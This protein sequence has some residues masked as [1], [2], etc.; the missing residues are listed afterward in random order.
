MKAR[1]S[2]IFYILAGIEYISRSQS[3]PQPL[4]SIDRRY[5]VPKC[6]TVLRAIWPIL[7]AS[8]LF[9]SDSFTQSSVKPLDP[10]N[11]DTSVKPA[12]DFFR[13]A[14]G[15]CSPRNCILP[16]P[17]LWGRFSELQAKNSAVLRGI[18]EQAANDKSAADG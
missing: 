17:P 9:T 12:D 5:T 7:C 1:H 15:A 16:A 4:K 13:F 10:T 6:P 8:L 18:L 2:P 14:T 11:F 3:T